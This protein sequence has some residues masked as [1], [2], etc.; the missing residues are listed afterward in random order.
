MPI[1][2]EYDG[3]SIDVDDVPLEVYET[4]KKKTGDEW[5]TVAGRPMANA[6]GGKLLAEECAKLL[7]VELPSPMTPRILVDVFK[8]V[9]ESNLPAEYTDGMPDPK[10]ADTGQETT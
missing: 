7:G 4:I 1:I 8:V 6:A 2:F 9:E 5:Y 3:K 10:A